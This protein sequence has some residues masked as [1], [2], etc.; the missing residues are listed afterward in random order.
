[1]QQEHAADTPQAEGEGSSLQATSV[2]ADTLHEYLSDATTE[3]VELPHSER[4][5]MSSPDQP[6]CEVK[7]SEDISEDSCRAALTLFLVGSCDGLGPLARHAMAYIDSWEQHAMVVAAIPTHRTKEGRIQHISELVAQLH[8]RGALRIAL[9]LVNDGTS[10]GF[11][12]T[13]SAV[14]DIRGLVSVATLG[15]VL[16]DTTCLE[17]PPI[18]TLHV[19]PP[20]VSGPSA[21]W[22]EVKDHGHSQAVAGVRRFVRQRQ[23]PPTTTMKL[24]PPCAEL[25]ELDSS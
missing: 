3:A 25:W 19:L 16:S 13:Q 15:L 23:S 5:Q 1:M 4:F 9:V 20:G 7:A 12:W 11:E 8:E 10:S 17:Q 22:Y 6:V 2:L 21:W 18:P 14:Y 24:L